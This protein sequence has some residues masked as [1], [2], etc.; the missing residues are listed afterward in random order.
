MEA[1][2]ENT[3][4]VDREDQGTSPRWSRRR[5]LTRTA[6]GAAAL[7]AAACGR[8]GGETSP[9][10]TPSAAESPLGVAATGDQVFLPYVRTGDGAVALAAEPTLTP[11]PPKATDTPAPTDTP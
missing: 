8:G 10:P 7:I 1:T 2:P 9:L 4:A 5:F 6:T 11:T 3:D